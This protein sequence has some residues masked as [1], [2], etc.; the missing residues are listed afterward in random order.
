MGTG[1]F[2][3]RLSAAERRMLAGLVA[4]PIYELIPLDGARDNA[5]PLPASAPMT[6]TVSARLG[7]DA[8]LSLA[9]WLSSRGHDVAPHLA[10]RLIRDRAHLADV[11][12]RLRTAGIRKVFIVGGD[13][14]PIGDVHD[15]LTLIRAIHAL[16][17]SF[18]EIGV[19]AYPE[20]HPQIPGEVLLR[21]LKEKQSHVQAMTTQMSFN[22]SAVSTW[23]EQIRSEAITLPIHLG[24][25]GAVEL[26]KLMKIAA[27]IGV[28]DST[29]Y[30]LK[31][32]SLIG[33]LVQR[34]AFGPD[35][36][37]RDL[38]RTL[39]NPGAD[40]RALHVFTMNQVDATL[41]WQQRMLEALG[42]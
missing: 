9:E 11:L 20:G 5:S 16:G 35:E 19:P 36:F 17:H 2:G 28:A 39:A 40:V 38:A 3:K 22:P 18:D 37:L 26:R 34:G 31:H 15:G 7:L 30:L 4:K 29:R 24:I 6:V 14:P 42:D 1:Q 10:A 27:R 41:A 13:G 25:P 21:D 8:T 33:H 23:I 32:R 12:D